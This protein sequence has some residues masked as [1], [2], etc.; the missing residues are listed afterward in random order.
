MV[1]T[2][3]NAQSKNFEKAK[4]C[5]EKE[6]YAQALKKIEKAKKDKAKENKSALYL[7]ESQIYLQLN[8]QEPSEDFEKKAVKAAIKAKDQA[9]DPQSFQQSHA[10]F[11]AKIASINMKDA[12]SYY[13]QGRYSK[14]I[15]LLKRSLE[16]E[17]DSFTK[18]LLAKSYIL[19]NDYRRGM[20]LMDEVLNEQFNIYQKSEVAPPFLADG[21]NVYTSALQQK[22]FSDSAEI[23]L[24][25]G[26]E[27]FPTDAPL[28]E[29]QKVIWVDIVKSMPLSLSLFQF[30][31]NATD[32]YP[33]DSFFTF[34]KNG[35]Y[36]MFIANE[37]EGK[38]M[39]GNNDWVGKF[40]IEK[41]NLALKSSSPRH[42][43][44]D[45]FLEKDS[46]FIMEKLIF[47]F[48][49][50]E[51]YKLQ[52]ELF[53]RYAQGK[54]NDKYLSAIAHLQELFPPAQI[55]QLY[56]FELSRNYSKDG[57]KQQLEWYQ[58]LL[59]TDRKSEDLFEA[60]LTLNQNISRKSTS[61]TEKENLKKEYSSII[62]NYW[63]L[64]LEKENFWKAYE[65][66]YKAKELNEKLATTYWKITIDKDFKANYYESRIARE[67]YE[68][69]P[70]GYTWNGDPSSCYPGYMEDSILRKIIQRINY[71][72]RT[73]GLLDPVALNVNYNR[74]C[75]E[76][77]LFYEANKN[78]TH[79]LSQELFCYTSRAAQAGKMS[80]LTEGV[81]TSLA[82]T[83]F[84]AD[85]SPITGNRR[86]LLYPPTRFMGIGSSNNK[87]AL[88]CVNEAEWDTST[89][90][91][92]GVAWPA[93]G[94]SPAIFQF[95]YWSY[96]AYKDFTN[97]KVQ[98]VDLKTNQ[99]I[100]C[101][102]MNVVKGYGMPTLVWMPSLTKNVSALR[103]YDVVIIL[104]TG[105]KIQYKTHLVPT[106]AK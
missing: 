11:Y 32:V 24:D 68:E 30:L 33:F 14:A 92:K 43:K 105:E 44:W 65:L 63:N 75:Q 13:N 77:V 62:F 98:M 94:Y 40:L 79:D 85:N 37:L 20:P 64:C 19:Y 10:E 93:P 72:R 89:Y 2:Q 31:D 76:A 5:F 61:R 82:I 8:D 26:L 90:I 1:F 73:A 46:N 99:S 71:F 22:G 74:A 97:A 54:F 58:K 51:N 87:T 100:P 50:F 21:F 69:N 9:E 38:K 6:K 34:K 95:K 25:M 4:V 84:M 83:S 39:E 101:Q 42:K 56:A 41:Q 78:L 45:Y 47:Y 35:V 17:E 29:K 60:L 27:M 81:H 66:G 52:H 80:L 12:M 28:L 86:W 3:T 55:A 57:A 53:L 59:N 103:S 104:N 102:I 48:G 23:Y 49:N 106:N 16:L 96:S 88:W 18:Y 67:N 7:L 36:L 91:N 70:L 15:T